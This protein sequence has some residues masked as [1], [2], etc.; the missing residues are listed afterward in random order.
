M[1][2]VTRYKFVT[3]EMAVHLAA[4]IENLSTISLILFL[5]SSWVVH[6][7]G[8]CTLIRVVTVNLYVSRGSLCTSRATIYRFNISWSL[9]HD[10]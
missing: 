2:G 3:K 1:F 6:T 7:Q 8:W 9:N 10:E 4:K 5:F